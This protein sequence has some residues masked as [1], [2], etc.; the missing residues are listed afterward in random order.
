MQILCTNINGQFNNF[1]ISLPDSSII[2]K[3][4]VGIY[5]VKLTAITTTTLCHFRMTE[6]F[7][8]CKQRFGS[9]PDLYV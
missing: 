5:T 4:A 9:N 1:N 8:L 3:F 6:F 7:P 2:A